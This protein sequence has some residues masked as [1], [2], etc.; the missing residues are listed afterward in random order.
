MKALY[1]YRLQGALLLNGLLPA[2][3]SKQLF[4]WFCHFVYDAQTQDILYEKIQENK[5]K[6][7]IAQ[8]NRL[9]KLCPPPEA[10]ACEIS[11]AWNTIFQNEKSSRRMKKIVFQGKKF[12]PYLDRVNSEQELEELFLEFLKQKF[13]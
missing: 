2:F 13:S 3:P 5:Q 9:K 4:M 8:L 10:S 1:L 6:L 11:D 7:C 12:A